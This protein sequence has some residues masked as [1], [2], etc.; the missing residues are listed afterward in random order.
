MKILTKYILSV[1]Y[2]I[3]VPVASL[4]VLY[5]TISAYVLTPLEIIGYVLIVISI[6]V[7]CLV[8]FAL[9][10]LRIIPRLKITIK[11]NLLLGFEVVENRPEMYL[12]ILCISIKIIPQKL[13]R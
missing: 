3:V 12:H 13:T 9:L 7:T 4:Y 6:F 10:N 1:V 11:P 5:K 8:M 2:S